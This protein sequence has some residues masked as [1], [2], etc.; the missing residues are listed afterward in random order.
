[1]RS[2]IPLMKAGECSPP[3]FLA[4]STASLMA[5]WGGDVL[6]IA[7]LIHGQAQDIAIDGVQA[8]QAPALR[9]LRYD[10]IDLGK[11]LSS[12]PMTSRT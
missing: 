5:T 4:S 12:P 6:A 11:L 10:S 7:E 1:M 9:P 3:Y 2:K 8:L